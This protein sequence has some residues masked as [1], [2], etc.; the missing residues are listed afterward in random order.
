MRH[1][2]WKK[3]KEEEEEDEEISRVLSQEEYSCVFIEYC[4]DLS[5]FSF[6]HT[7]NHLREFSSTS[8]S[9]KTNYLSQTRV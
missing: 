3:K 7:G 1:S 8:E 2:R 5:F 6:E 4:F 9:A